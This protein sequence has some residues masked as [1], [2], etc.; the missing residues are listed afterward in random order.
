[1]KIYLAG[2]IHGSVINECKLWRRTIVNHY[3]NW[4]NSGKMYGNISF[5]DPCNGEEQ[6][7]QDGLSS[8]LPAKVIF[9]KDYNSVK[10]CDLLIANMNNF[11]VSRPLIGTTMEVAFAYE[12]HKPVILIT[13]QEV[14]RKHPFF[15]SIVS[16][17]FNDINEML[18]TKAIQLFFKSWVNVNYN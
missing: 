12:F 11:G 14:Y 16:W 17:Y 4:K 10:N 8:N 1:M 3:N 6:V 18:N 5:L 7:S 2:L 15:T 13:D 9:D